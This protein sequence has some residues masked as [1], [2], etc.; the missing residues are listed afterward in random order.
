MKH[1]SELQPNML[2]DDPNGEN[3]SPAENQETPV[4]APAEAEQA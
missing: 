2:V 4:A 1:Y 3:A